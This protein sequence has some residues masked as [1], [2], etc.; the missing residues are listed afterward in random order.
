M[1][2]LET[3]SG[4]IAETAIISISAINTRPHCPPWHDV[5]YRVGREA[6]ETRASKEAVERYWDAGARRRIL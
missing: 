3:R 6:R 5:T 1:L 4:T 2:F